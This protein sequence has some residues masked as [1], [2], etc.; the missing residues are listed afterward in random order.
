MS[1]NALSPLDGRYQYQAAE[2]NKHFS[3]AALMR[4]RVTVEIHW[5]IQLAQNPQI[6]ELAAL[7]AR[8][9]EDLVQ[10]ATSFSEE[11]AL[12]IKAI[13][14]T[15]NHDVKAVEYWLKQ[16]FEAMNLQ[17]S[18]EFIHFACTSEDINNLSHA[19]MLKGACQ[20][21]IIPNMQKIVEAITEIA[22]NYAAQPMLSRTHGQTASPSTLG[23][24]M[25]VFAYRLQRQVQQLKN[26]EFLG[27][28]NGAVGNYN[29]H[30]SAYPDCNWAEISAS[31]I[32]GLG[33]T[34]N[35]Y[36][37]QIE[38]HDYMAEIFH[39]VSRFNQ[40]LLD[41]YYLLRDFK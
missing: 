21:V 27:K 35:P 13:E 29:A 38:S 33:L 32:N 2:L 8:Q 9:V 40:I 1:I 14:A 25:A 10:I 3:E 12:A 19:L 37:T 31:F 7:T 18:K 24:E 23:K 34:P 17:D 11:D 28:M 15:T 22:E 26:Q 6:K 41:F 30:L 39:S 16:K 36:T 20:E 4:C 5:F